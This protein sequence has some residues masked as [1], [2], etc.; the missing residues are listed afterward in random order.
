MNSGIHGNWTIDNAKSR[1]HQFMQM[2]KINADY[3][4]SEIGP[5]HNKSFIAEMAIF[6][7][8]LN[9]KVH[10]RE[11]GS[12]KQIA[13]KSCA[14]SLVRQLFHLGAIDAYTGV[15]K[16]K[17]ESKLE[18]YEVTL[19]PEIAEELQATINA[20]N[21]EAVYVPQGEQEQS[22]EPFSLKIPR[23]LEGEQVVSQPVPGGVVPWSPP[24]QNWNPWTS[25]NIDEG[26]MATMT[27]PQISENILNSYNE[28]I[29]HDPKLKKMLDERYQLPVYNSY[30]C[31]L[32][33]VHQSPIVIIRGA[34]GCGKTTQVPQYILDSYINQGIGAECC[35]VVTQPRRISAVSVAERIAEERSEELG[36]SA[37]YSVRFESVLPRPYGSILFCT[38]GVLLRK[39]EAGLRGVSH[40]IIDE[41]HERD[42]NTDFIM[43]V[44][45]DMIR[46]FPQLR[47]ILMSAT[48]DVTLF[49]AYFDNCPVIEVE[50]RAH[51]V[52]EYF[53]EDCI[54]LVNFVTPP[55]TK[56]RRRDEEE[57]ET[58]E[59]DEN[60]NKVIDPSYKQSTRL[61]MSQLDEKTLSFELI[62]ALLLHIK[63]LPEK[64]AVLVFLPGWNLIFALMRHLQQHPIF[65]TSQYL[66]LPLHS[67]VPREEQHRVFRPVGDNVT[68]VIL[69]TNIAETSITI[70]DVVYV[71]DSCKAKMKLFTSHNNMTNYATVFASKTNLEQRRGRAGRVRPGHCYHLCSR[72]RYEKLDNYTTPE[73]FRTPLH[74]LALA[75]KLLRL[76]DITKFLAKA[77]EPPPLDAVIE[78]E[79]LLREMGALTVYGELTPLGK[80]LARLPIEPRLGKMLILGLIFGAGDALCTIS[81]NSSTFPEP[82]DTP[83]PKRLGYVHRR[84]F[85]GRW[86]DHITLLN[87]FGQWEEAHM[88]GEY[89]ESGF[90]EQFSISMPTLRI[91]HDAKVGRS[92]TLG[93]HSFPKV[94]ELQKKRNEKNGLKVRQ[95]RHFGSRAYM[96]KKTPQECRS[97][98]LAPPNAAQLRRV[99]ACIPLG[100]SK[101]ML[102]SFL[103]VQIRTRAVS[104]KQMTMI[105][106]LH[107]LLFGC[108][109]VELIGD[110]VQVDGWIN[111]KI[112]PQV[113]ANVLALQ[114]SVDNLIT[115]VTADP[116]LLSQPSEDFSRIV[117]VV[118]KL[119]KFDSIQVGAENADISEAF[120]GNGPPV[121]KMPR[122]SNV[123]GGPGTGRDFPSDRGNFRGGFRGGY[124]GGFG[125]EGRGDFRGGYR[126]G[127]RGGSG[128][129]GGGGYG[130]GGGYRGGNSRGG[131]FARGGGGYGGDNGWRG[132][133]NGSYGSGGWGGSRGGRGGYQSTY[134][135]GY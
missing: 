9:M 42:V 134:S 49:Q 126:G 38:V 77:L 66:I 128:G 73:I 129:Y 6:V 36:Q 52:Q 5:S 23:H 80:I 91:T 37:G 4:Y 132:G 57:V 94:G 27:L 84:F 86:S 135:G 97:V 109:R 85:G 33:A 41:I 95:V 19:K 44:V 123:G 93:N 11:Q 117:D 70:N 116:E 3:T 20:L 60:L 122:L 79:V 104:C 67:Q 125:G 107:I 124:R 131:G 115:D 69:S 7:R 43:V 53:L 62:E 50:G 58:D 54:E 118:K 55:N 114:Q 35:I 40:V 96:V 100:V 13:S 119:C 1:L 32:D 83:F 28:Q 72:A 120:S 10:A 108:K 133:S 130:G 24:Q 34:T 25:C 87:V 92:L 75:I 103:L 65:G 76:G 22:Q 8:K 31:I 113:A 18:P 61:A 82:F 111:L 51:P 101:N 21:I 64:G 99:K 89:A 98:I 2:N 46:A 14:L 68:K 112:D 121:R 47:V 127:F 74:E 16:K 78:S 29:D 39:L 105:S 106:P 90:C 102:L 26:P 59:S 88:R 45:R 15:T 17:A 110:M 12:N 56:K 63:T 71:I 81:A 48:I 30:D